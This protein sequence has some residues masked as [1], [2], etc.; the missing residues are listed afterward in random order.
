MWIDECCQVQIQ[1]KICVDASISKFGL[2]P[3][4]F[5]GGFICKAEHQNEGETEGEISYPWFTPKWPQG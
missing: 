2:F 5:E 4:V 1:I 3:S